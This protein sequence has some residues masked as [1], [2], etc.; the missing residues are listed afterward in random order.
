MVSDAEAPS[1]WCSP[2]LEHLAVVY[3]SFYLPG[4]FTSITVTTVDI[5]S[6]ADIHLAPEKLYTV[7]QCLFQ[8]RGINK[9]SLKKSLPNYHQH[10]QSC[11]ARGSNTPDQHN[12]TIKDA[13]RSIPRPQGNQSTW[14]SPFFLRIGSD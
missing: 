12:S 1:N 3:C 9:V 8:S 5:P 10:M 11:S 13:Y 4:E 14:L 6:Q 7:V 2:H